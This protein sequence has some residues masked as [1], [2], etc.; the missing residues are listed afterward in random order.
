MV[1]LTSWAPELPSLMMALSVEGRGW[2]A[3]WMWEARTHGFPLVPEGWDH[4]GHVQYKTD[5]HPAWK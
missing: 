4:R 5:A 3:A 1:D 2:E